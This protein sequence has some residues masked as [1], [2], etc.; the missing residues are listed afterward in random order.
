ME[1]DITEGLRKQ[2]W[3]RHV[4]AREHFW[5]HHVNQSAR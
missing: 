1:N 3:K 5:R 2:P 4:R